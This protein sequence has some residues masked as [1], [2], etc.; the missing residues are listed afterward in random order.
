MFKGTR[1]PVYGIVA[2]LD[3]GASAGELLAGY[4]KLTK[5]MIELARVWVCAHPRRGR[6][7]SLKD[8]GLTVKNS[9]RTPLKGDP[10]SS[11]PT[12]L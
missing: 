6:P 12:P 7:K 1:I 3:A 4:P 9:R 8:L 2:M 5:R 10:L 11:G